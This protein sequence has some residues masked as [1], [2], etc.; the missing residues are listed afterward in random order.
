MAK[1]GAN[2]SKEKSIDGL[3]CGSLKLSSLSFGGAP[4]GNLY[5]G[6]DDAV[7]AAAVEK[8]WHLQVRHFDT[9]PYYGYGL[10]EL[11]LGNVLSSLPRDSF[12]LSTKVG[13]LI[14]DASGSTSHDGFAVEGKRAI[15]DYSRDGILRSVE[16]SL[17]RLRT[18]RIDILLLHDIGELTHGERHPA[19][20]KQALEEALPTMAELRAQGVCRAI[21]IG[22]NE[23][24]VC[25]QVMPRFRLDL[26]MLA[27]RYTLFEQARSEQVMVMAQQ[28]QVAVLAAGPYNS[29]LLGPPDAPGHTYDYAPASAAVRT[30][31]QR[32][33]DICA[34]A[35]VDVGA[36]A[37]QFPLAH[38]AV[39]SVVCGLRSA[40]EVAVSVQRLGQ[41][42]PADTWRQLRNANLLG[43]QTPVPA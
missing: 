43:T 21:G 31:A 15:F 5:Q 40:D 23:E 39:V 32:F 11:R 2:A 16:T 12:T 37:L 17:K 29:G 24:A 18:D 1:P 38:P 4:L 9:A 25:L 42:I 3:P 19:I 27:G 30:R 35:G 20:L 28:Q 34:A 7:A 36:A 10:S 33:Y 14:E 26:I 6:V 41:H 13:R 22:V 8:A